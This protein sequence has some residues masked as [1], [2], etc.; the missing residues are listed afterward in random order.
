MVHLSGYLRDTSKE[1]A[2]ELNEIGATVVKDFDNVTVSWGEI[3]L[4]FVD[5][6]KKADL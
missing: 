3:D 1:I 5:R 2:V 6:L 4:Y